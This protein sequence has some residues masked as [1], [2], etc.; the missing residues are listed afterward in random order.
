MTD[1]GGTTQY[2][3]DPQTDRLT[4]KQTPFGTISYTYD[5]GGNVLSITSSNTNGAAMSYTYDKLNR[6]G[7]VTVPGQSPTTYTYDEVGNLAGYTYPNGVATSYAYDPLNRLTQVS[8]AGLQAGGPSLVAQYTYTLGAAGNRLS[9]A[10]LSGRTV[11]YA[12][13]DLY[14]LTSETIT[15]SNG[16][17]TFTCGQNNQ[18]CGAIS[19]TYDAV[20]NRQQRNSTLAAIPTTGLLYYDANDRTSTDSFDADGNTVSSAG[21]QNA[22]DF[23]NHL[24]QHGNVT[25]VYDGD[26]NRVAETAGGVSTR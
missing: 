26:G 18:N 6:L 21:I 9:V 3:Y 12:Y 25:V 10:E 1:A 5:A 14:R 7:T 13:D 11:A 20:G 23:E 8:S 19:Y 17:T 16:P 22:Y 24:I 2:T 4:T 15:A